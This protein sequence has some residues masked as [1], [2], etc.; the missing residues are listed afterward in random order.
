MLNT[1]TSL[2]NLSDSHVFTCHIYLHPLSTLGR[3]PLVTQLWQRSGHPLV[4][5]RSR[6][7][8][9]KHRPGH[10]QLLHPRLRQPLVAPHG[11]QRVCF[12]RCPRHATAGGEA[13]GCRGRSTPACAPGQRDPDVQRWESVR[14]RRVGMVLVAVTQILGLR[15]GNLGFGNLERHREIG[16]TLGVTGG[17]HLASVAKGRG[18]GEAREGRALA[19]REITAWLTAL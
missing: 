5:R 15:R 1:T 16:R 17:R 4:H 13:V 14:G 11:D 8:A 9:R 3:G 19:P 6:R 12:R 7:L 2:S 10:L 18:K